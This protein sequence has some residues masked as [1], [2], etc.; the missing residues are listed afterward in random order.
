[1]TSK[2]PARLPERAIRPVWP[3]LHV[4]SEELVSSEGHAAERVAMGPHPSDQ[5]PS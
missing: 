4:L 3:R 2:R 5:A 1:M